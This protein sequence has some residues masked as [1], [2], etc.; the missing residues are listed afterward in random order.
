MKHR[1]NELF[2][3]LN[4]VLHKADGETYVVLL[5]NH[6]EEFAVCRVHYERRTLSSI[7]ANESTQ[8]RITAPLNNSG[9]AQI[10]E[11]KPRHHAVS[12]VSDLFGPYNADN[13]IRLRA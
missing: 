12:M 3:P 7:K 11:W 6:I 13:V 5:T 4:V 2:S 1:L 10:L 9:I 8:G